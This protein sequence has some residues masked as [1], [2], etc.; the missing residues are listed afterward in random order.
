MC[1]CSVGTAV[2]LAAVRCCASLCLP[3]AVL[4]VFQ[5]VFSPGGGVSGGDGDGGVAVAGSG[6]DDG[7]GAVGS[8]V[9]GVAGSVCLA[10]IVVVVVGCSVLY[11]CA[12]SL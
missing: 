1:C 2:V 11:V 10:C 6:G 12:V 4:R 9:G 5:R 3:A 8:V 7:A